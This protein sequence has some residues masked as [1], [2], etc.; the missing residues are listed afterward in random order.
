MSGIQPSALS[1]EELLRYAHL[2]NSNGLAREWAD[3]LLYHLDDAHEERKYLRDENEV[4]ENRVAQ[5]EDDVTT[6]EE[7]VAELELPPEADKP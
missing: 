2:E 3:A 4:L 5:L 1:V 6:L 7:R